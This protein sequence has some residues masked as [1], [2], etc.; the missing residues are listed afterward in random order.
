MR[1]HFM[2]TAIVASAILLFAGDFAQAQRYGRGWGG[3]GY[4]RPYGYGGYRPYYY[5]GG[6]STYP[7]GYGSGYRYGPAYGWTPYYDQLEYGISSDSSAAAPSSSSTYIYRATI[8]PHL[9][10]LE[11]P[12]MGGLL[13]VCINV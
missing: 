1:R 13:Y 6:Y 12:I 10:N 2:L 7:Y 8:F 11:V 4:Y 9:V 5:G 3:G